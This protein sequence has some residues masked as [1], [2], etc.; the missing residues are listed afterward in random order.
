LGGDPHVGSDVGDLGGVVAFNKSKQG[1]LNRK[2]LGGNLMTKTNEEKSR[3][4]R[5]K[6]ESINRWMEIEE[7]RQ[8][9]GGRLHAIAMSEDRLERGRTNPI[10]IFGI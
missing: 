3:F 10:P 7:H 8:K 4:D 1:M 9:V 6:R 2:I 5:S